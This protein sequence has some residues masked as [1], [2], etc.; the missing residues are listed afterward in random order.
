MSCVV[1]QPEQ[2]HTDIL[3]S[4]VECGQ[5]EV[6]NTDVIVFFLSFIAQDAST[7]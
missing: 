1:L 4:K 5:E 3:S 6:H 2:Q 7:N